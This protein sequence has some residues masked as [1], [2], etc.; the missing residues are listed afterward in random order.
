MAN[1]TE[2]ISPETLRLARVL[3]A[4][5]DPFANDVHKSLNWLRQPQRGLGEA[6]PIDLALTE[7]GS[8]SVIRL[9]GQI[10]WGIIG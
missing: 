6:I 7:A 3:Q 9:L 5:L 8:E 2:G 4:T 10:S 1:L